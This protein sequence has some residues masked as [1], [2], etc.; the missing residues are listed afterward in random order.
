[1]S[2]MFSH[3]GLMM[4]PLLATAAGILWLSVRTGLR[5]A[6]GDR[7]R[8]EEAGRGL[9]AILFWGGMA[10]VLGLLGTVIGIITMTQAIQLAGVAEP[11]LVWGGIGVVLTTLLFGL[12]V[13]LLSAVSWFVLRQ[14]HGRVERRAGA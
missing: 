10:V 3:G 5:L 9:Q 1:M 8:V 13:F 12:L 2:T 4:W 6:G 11:R 14:W 7:S